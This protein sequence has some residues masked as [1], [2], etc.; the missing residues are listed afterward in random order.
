MA[1]TEVSNLVLLAAMLGDSDE[2]IQLVLN[3][4]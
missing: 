2:T 1:H 3:L 4:L